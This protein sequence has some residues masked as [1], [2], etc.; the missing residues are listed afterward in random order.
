MN[1]KE[2]WQK[3]GELTKA[4]LMQK[5]DDFADDMEKAYKAASESIE[6]DISVFFQRFAKN[7]GITLAE[8]NKLLKAGELEQFK[9]TVEE[10]IQKGIENSVS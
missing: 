2:Y 9:M 6:K 1:S 7:E 10:Y 5:A 4:H 3:R 8:A